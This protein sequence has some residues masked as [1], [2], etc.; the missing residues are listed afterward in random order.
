MTE[1]SCWC[2]FLVRQEGERCPWA[3]RCSSEHVR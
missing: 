3:A 2:H 1:Q